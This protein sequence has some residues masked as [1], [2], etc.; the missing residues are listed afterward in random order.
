[1]SIIR[2]LAAVA[3]TTAT[4]LVT[5]TPAS[6]QTFTGPRVEVKIGLDQ[7]RY[8][9][10]TAPGSTR[11]KGTDFGYGATVG[12]DREV[13]PNL[14]IGVEGGAIFSDG[15]Y[16][17]SSAAAIDLTHV[18][19]DLFAAARIGTRVGA[20]ALVY[21]KVGY[22]NLEL[23]TETRGAAVP[24]YNRRN[25]DGVLLGAGAEVGLT[26]NTY[27]K[28]E[29]RYTNYEDGVSRQNILTGIGIRF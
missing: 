1:M 7:L 28:S 8:D 14:V 9:L 12:Y 24:T 4:F 23:G 6:A 26:A 17:R 25:Y 13:Q 27:L 2:P 19:R 21:G 10:G 29:Y 5:A 15:D 18:R 3:L 16:A 22:S 11:E 20:N